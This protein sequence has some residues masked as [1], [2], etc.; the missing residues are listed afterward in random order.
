M[1]V[2]A[3]TYFGISSPKI[4]YISRQDEEFQSLQQSVKRLFEPLFGDLYEIGGS[5][6]PKDLFSSQGIMLLEFIPGKSLTH[7][8]NGQRSLSYEDYFE[9]GKM[10]LFDLLI[11][12]TDRFPC[13]KAL[14][15][16]NSASILDDGNAGN[17]MFGHEN[18]VIWSIDPELQ[19]NVDDLLHDRYAEALESVVKEIVFRQDLDRRY[20]SIEMLFFE[21]IPGLEDVLPLPLHD[22]RE[23]DK[24]NKFEK[25]AIA[26]ILQLIRV[27]L[28]KDGSTLTNSVVAVSIPEDCG[29]KAWRELIRQLAPRVM[30]DVFLFLELHSGYSTPYYASEA[31]CKGFISSLQSAVT[32][33]EEYH[34]PS[35][36]FHRQM[37]MSLEDAA[38]K[39]SSINI[40]FVLD[41]IDCIQPYWDELSNNLSVSLHLNRSEGK[42]PSRSRY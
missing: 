31:F 24:C 28:W 38:E 33:K 35:T 3:T 15:R 37:N 7:R 21:V 18:G 16:P 9:I 17:V 4:R 19:I 6:S 42:R 11:R 23:W 1:N 8:R 27:K 2:L 25:D 20:K 26:S 34:H 22:I 5:R 10:F 36:P 41:M 32:F 40:R 29:E 12:N 13:N 39:E 14:K 30:S